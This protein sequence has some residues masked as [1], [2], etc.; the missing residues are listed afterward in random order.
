LSIT[1]DKSNRIIRVDGV[2]GRV[3]S[4]HA[5]ANASKTNWY[6]LVNGKLRVNEKFDFN[7]QP[8]RLQI[9]KHYIFLATNPVNKLEYGHQAI[10]ANN[11]ILTLNTVVTG[12]DFTL[13]SEH[14]VVNV[15]SGIGMYNTSIWDTWRTSFR[16]TIKLSNVTDDESSNRL[17]AWLTIG[18]GEFGKYSIQGAQD[19]ANYYKSVDG[20]FDKLMLSYD[21]EWLK[22]YYNRLYQK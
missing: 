2:N 11:K 10:V 8:D 1:K 21:W 9:A 5:A 6:F 12:L 22:D 15:N 4:Q 17:T 14:E 3:A 19:A 20:D 18:E 7:W 16:E 13:D